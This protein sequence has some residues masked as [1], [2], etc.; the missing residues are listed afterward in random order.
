MVKLTY[1][2][3]ST[4]P[5]YLNAVKDREIDLRGLKIPRIE[6]LAI[7]KDQHDVIDLTDNDIRKIE[8][9]PPMKRLTTLL[10]SNNRISRIDS[11]VARQLPNLKALILT[12]NQIGEL[13]DLD[14]LGEFTNLEFLSLVDNPVATKKHYRSYVIHRCPKVRILDFR[15]IKEKV[16]FS[17]DRF[18]SK[19]SMGTFKGCMADL[20]GQERNEAAELFSG[21]AGTA[22]A[23]SLSSQK[24]SNTFEPGEMGE[25]KAMRPF[26]GPSPE[27]AARIREAISKATSLE[28]ITKLEK[29]LRGGVV[30]GSGKH[31]GGGP[32]GGKGGNDEDVEMDG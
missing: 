31:G 22:L 8:N 12:N 28:E 20:H 15:R 9:F 5:S 3:L 29:Q 23:A 10:L 30:P 1:E 26:Q 18:F 16:S 19:L 4:A 6:N 25:K 13:G 11:D 17:K 7:T 27:E 32:S 14:P 21:A 2:V 24:A